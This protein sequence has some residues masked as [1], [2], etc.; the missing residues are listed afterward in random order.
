MQWEMTGAVP[1][2]PRQYAVIVL[3]AIIHRLINL[4]VLVGRG[5]TPSA[6]YIKVSYDEDDDDRLES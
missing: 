3:C 6:V 4:A 2:R 1:S 5:K